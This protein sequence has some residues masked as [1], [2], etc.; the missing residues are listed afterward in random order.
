MHL[1]DQRRVHRGYALRLRV[2]VP[3]HAHSAPLQNS[4]TQHGGVGRERFG[5]VKNHDAVFQQTRCPHVQW[6]HFAFARGAVALPVNQLLKALRRSGYAQNQVNGRNLSLRPSDKLLHHRL[7]GAFIRA[8]NL[9]STVRLVND[10]IEAV[11]LCL[12]RVADGFPNRVGALVAAPRSQQLVFAQFLRIDEIHLATGK[13]FT[14][15]VSV[16]DDQIAIA[17]FGRC[18]CNAFLGLLIQHRLV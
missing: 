15:K 11:G 1:D 14:V 17:Q 12:G 4:S 3:L 9:G 10:Q 7:P 8:R 16:H 13:K 5:R 6:I 18:G 2:F